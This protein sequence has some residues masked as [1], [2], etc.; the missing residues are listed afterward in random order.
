VRELAPALAFL[1]VSGLYL[2]TSLMFPLG[3]AVRPG[4]GFFP[5]AVGAYLTALAVVLLAAA[6]RQSPPPARSGPGAAVAPDARGRVAV[7]MAA[8][9]GFCLALGW[10]GYPVSAFLFT[11][12]LLKGLGRGRWPGVLMMAFVAAGASY[13]LFGVLLGVPLPRGVLGT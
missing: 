10:I 11:A 7:V 4:A 1:A 8:L 12:V 6:W 5:A 2:A 13:Y 3:S 9:V